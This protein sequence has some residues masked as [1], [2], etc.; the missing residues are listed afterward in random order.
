M[1]EQSKKIALYIFL[2]ALFISLAFFIGTHIY[3]I[4]ITSKTTSEQTT[5][6]S[7]ECA[8]S[9]SLSKIRYEFPQLSFDLQTSDINAFKKL[10]LEVEGIE[11]EVPLREF[12]DYEQGVIVED[13]VIEDKFRAYPL[14]CRD[15]NVKECSTKD[16]DCVTLK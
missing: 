8:F 14:G 3:N 16:R 7:L 9:F 1:A 5:K 10:V 4:Y 2:F 15:Y 13:V 6:S 11:T 12:M